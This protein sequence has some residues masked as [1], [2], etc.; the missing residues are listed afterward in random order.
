[1]EFLAAE[2]MKSP[3]QCAPSIIILLCHSQTLEMAVML[4][5]FFWYNYALLW[6]VM[7]K[8][9]CREIYHCNFFF[10]QT[11]CMSNNFGTYIVNI[12]INSI[13]L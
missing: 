5:I 3:V 4:L 12:I 13:V 9:T 2:L 6:S 1:M 11:L 10:W 8:V 7:V